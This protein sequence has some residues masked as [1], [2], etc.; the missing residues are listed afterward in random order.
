MTLPL[1]IMESEAF[2]R[3]AALHTICLF[4]SLNLYY[5]V[6][7]SQSAGPDSLRPH[8]DCSPPGSFVNGIFQARILQWVAI[9]FSR[10]SSQFRD[11][12]RI[13]CIA[14]RFFTIC[15][16]FFFSYLNLLDAPNLLSRT[17]VIHLF[18]KYFCLP[19][20]D[21]IQALLQ[22]IFLLSQ[23]FSQ[24]FGDLMPLTP[25]QMQSIWGESFESLCFC[26]RVFSIFFTS[27]KTQL[28]PNILVQLTGSRCFCLNP[29][30]PTLI[31]A[32]QKFK[33]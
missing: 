23:Q 7:V 16:F 12:T 17:V 22:A 24:C 11:Q 19:Y 5:A 2:H 4:Y 6:C 13:S 28:P 8:M 33:S 3:L 26:S 20:A 27:K 14:S 25:F 1:V 29:Y 18:S 21:T 31:I 10:V 9:P 32:N 30:H 15:Q